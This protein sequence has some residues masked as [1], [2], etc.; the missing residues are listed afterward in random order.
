VAVSDR[1]AT[2]YDTVVSFTGVDDID[3]QVADTAN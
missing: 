2:E 3:V 1:P